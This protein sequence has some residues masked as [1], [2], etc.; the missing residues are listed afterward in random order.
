MFFITIACETPSWINLQKIFVAD[1]HELGHH[2][3][4]A[5]PD[6][7]SASFRDMQQSNLSFSSF[8]PHGFPNSLGLLS[9]RV[10]NEHL[11]VPEPLNFLL[12]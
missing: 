11:F 5:A 2:C 7:S 3:R 1:V 12:A 4:M 9:I 10:V 6:R 8:V